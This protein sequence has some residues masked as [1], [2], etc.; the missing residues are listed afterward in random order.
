MQLVT[1]ADGIEAAWKNGKIAS[2][3]GVDGGFAAM[4]SSMAFLRQYYDLGARY[5][6]LVP[7]MYDNFRY[8]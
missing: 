1:T 7:T 3:I 8:N 4:D 6:K 2:M 5:M